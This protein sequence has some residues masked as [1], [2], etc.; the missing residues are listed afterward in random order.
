MFYDQSNFL[1]RFKWGLSGMRLVGG[2][3]S[4]LI[5]DDILSFST[6]VDVAVSRGASI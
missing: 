1:I 4:I 6:C 5:I 2:A 3:S